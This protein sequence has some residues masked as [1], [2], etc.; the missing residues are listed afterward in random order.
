M[1]AEKCIHGGDRE[2]HGCPFEE[3]L[4]GDYEFRCKC[5]EDCQEECAWNI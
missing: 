2:A 5:C 1:S 3:D 4:N